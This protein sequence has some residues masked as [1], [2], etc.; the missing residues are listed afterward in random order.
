MLIEGG[1]RV[2][3]ADKE[4]FTPLHRCAQEE[5]VSGNDD[6][7]Q[8][9]DYKDKLDQAKAKVA[10][11]LLSKGADVNAK[12]TKGHQR[13]LHLAAMN[14]LAAVTKELLK[15]GADV[16]ATNK[17]LQTPLIYSIIEEH[18]P[19]IKIL[20]SGGADVNYGNSLHS[21]WA[22]IHWAA[23]TDNNDVLQAVLESD[24]VRNV[25]DRSGR[26]PDT[27]AVEHGKTNVVD[28]LRK[29]KKQ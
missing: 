25:K 7:D 28:R 12:E 2:S 24:D 4:G 5:P 13:P 15:A 17:I 21:D 8:A 14:G 6:E 19:V 3:G 18:P 22:A 11:L 10:S 16:N 26:Y 9:Q 29:L 23:L 20:V 27:L 1:A